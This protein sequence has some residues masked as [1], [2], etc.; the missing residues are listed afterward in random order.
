MS[1]NFYVPVN[2]FFGRGELDKLSERNLPGKK[3]LVVIS[4]GKSARANGYLDRLLGQLKKANID[5]AIFDKVEPNPLKSTVMAGAKTAKDNAC[6]FVVALGGG[7]VMDA[8]KAI[9]GMATNDGDLWEYMPWGTGKAKALKNKAL[10]LVCIST[11]AG[12]GSEIDNGAVITNPETNE[13]TAYFGEFPYLSIVDA[14]LMASVPPRQTAY[15]GFDALFH[16]TEAYIATTANLMS[17]MFARAAIENVGKY[18][19][20]AVKNGQDM[21]AREGMAFANSMSGYVMCVGSCTSEHSLEHALSAYHQELPH[22]A[23]LIMISKAY[24]THMIKSGV[25]KERFVD[26]AKFLGLND[27]KEP[28][29]FIKALDKLQHECGVDNLKMSDYGI[30][31][32]EFATMAQNA[33]EC[34]SLLFEFDPVKLSLQDCQNIYQASYK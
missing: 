9:A 19:A 2:V 25:R 34:M 31:E 33:K 24:Y 14:D 20:R 32:D 28:M 22:G 16:S 4:N 27:A 23:G 11:T 1:F 21:E 12:T 17:D 29:D 5:Y 6:D 26:M 18:L 10:S 13:K 7:S 30:S 8:A 15:Q 3:A